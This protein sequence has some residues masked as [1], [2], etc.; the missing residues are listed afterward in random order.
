MADPRSDAERYN[1]Q[2]SLLCNVVGARV[3]AG[4]TGS[5][6]PIYRYHR[7]PASRDLERFERQVAALVR[8]HRLPP[9][10]RWR[11][12][13][14][15]LADY[16]ARLPES[17]P[18]ER[19]ARALHRQALLAGGRAGFDVA[20]GIHHGVGAEAYSRFTAP[21]R[22]IV[23]VFVHKEAF[24]LLGLEAPASDEEDEALRAEVMRASDRCR[25]V[26]RRLDNAINRR[27]LDQLF[28]ADLAAGAP[29]RTGTVMGV[30]RTKVHVQLD[31]PPVDIKVY[32][33]HLE[34]Q[35]G[36]RLR[37][38][39]DGVSV[40]RSGG[41]PVWAVGDPVAVRPAGQDT[42]RDR[43]RLELLPAPRDGGAGS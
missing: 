4:G 16:L 26:Q 17:G 20:P 3:L 36:G 19:I 32:L 12:G 10:W 1:E 21:M 40:R 27:L 13:R 29:P 42:P 5:L 24:E 43:W 35:V 14:E 30:T 31:S 37:P 39:R 18:G 41:R 8:R 23:G 7:P 9:S 38:G 11:H 34:E 22:E 25:G 33:R 2:I 15:S 6:Q 28:A